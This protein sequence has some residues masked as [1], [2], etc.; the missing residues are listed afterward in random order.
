MNV[1]LIHSGGM[2]S[3]VL[4]Y[5]LRSEGRGVRC[6]SVDYGQRH[7]RELDAARLICG[8]LGVESRV[9]DLRGVAPLL[10]GSSLTSPELAVPEGHYADESMR[11]TVV[12]NRNMLMLSLGIAWAVSTKS[13]AV[14]Y[15]AHSG[16]H[17]IYPDCRPEFIAAMREAAALCDWRRIELL[18]PFAG[19]DK[20]DIAR[21]GAKLGVPFEKTWTCY[22]GLERHCGRCGACVERREA[23]SRAGLL[24]PT[25]YAN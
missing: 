1:I 23:F 24:D 25:D 9:A 13:D 10:A 19:M 2:D 20:A 18:A 14:A 7:R 8:D 6:L 21:L 16:D 12:P 11:L 17:T 22:K 4:L 3:T 5:Q 15:A